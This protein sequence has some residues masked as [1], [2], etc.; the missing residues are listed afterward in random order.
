MV[1]PRSAPNTSPVMC[2]VKRVIRPPSTCT[3]LE[4]VPGRQA[5]PP[6]DIS[7][8]TPITWASSPRITSATPAESVPDRPGTNFTC[9]QSNGTSISPAAISVGPA[10][11]GR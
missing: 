5:R 10:G 7:A 4:C 3:H 6:D 9:A 8:G 1:W 11:Q 2:V